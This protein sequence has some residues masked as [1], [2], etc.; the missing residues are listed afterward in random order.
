MIM[1]SYVVDPLQSLQN[2]LFGLAYAK[3]EMRTEFFRFVNFR[4]SV[5][6]T[7]VLAP[8]VRAV[9]SRPRKRS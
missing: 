5:E 2:F 1:P 9:D 3:D 8:L 7:P 6:R 4:D